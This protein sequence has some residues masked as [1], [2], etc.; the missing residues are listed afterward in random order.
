MILRRI[1][2]VAKVPGNSMAGF[3]GDDNAWTATWRRRGGRGKI[4][5]SGGFPSTKRGGHNPSL[6]NSH[7]DVLL[8]CLF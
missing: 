1:A 4:L 5:L 3:W 8:W 2:D 7:P 6:D